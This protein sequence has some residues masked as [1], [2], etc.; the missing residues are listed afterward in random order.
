M[1]GPSLSSVPVPVQP[2][3][4]DVC[5][6]L[7]SQGK[8]S[9]GPLP[10]IGALVSLLWGCLL[11]APALKNGIGL[12]P[13]SS[14]KFTS[15][16]PSWSECFSC[17]FMIDS[18]RPIMNSRHNPCMPREWCPYNW[19]MMH[20]EA[21]GPQPWKWCNRIASCSSYSQPYVCRQFPGPWPW[22]LA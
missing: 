4:W 16:F 14:H 5:C 17:F 9:Q 22:G 21:K 12:D 20:K 2:C 6:I 11:A 1:E 18:L 8:Q 7:W 10:G 3:Q 13:K 15:L 19:A